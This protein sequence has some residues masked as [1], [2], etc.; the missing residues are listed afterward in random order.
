[1]DLFE[2]FCWNSFKTCD[3]YVGNKVNKIH[4][5]RLYHIYRDLHLGLLHNN[6]PVLYEKKS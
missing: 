6:M 2:L 4:N 5:Y 3:L 1:M